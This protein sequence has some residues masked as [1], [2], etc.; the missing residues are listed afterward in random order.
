MELKELLSKSLCLDL[1]TTHGGKIFKIGAVFQEHAFEKQG[2]FNLKEALTELDQFGADATYVLG[3]NLLGHDLPLLEVLSPQLTLLKKPVID[4]L[5]LSPLAFP[6]NPYHRLVKD[7]KLVRQSVNDP[8]ADARIAASIFADQWE[9]F[10]Q[11]HQQNPRTLDFYRFCF[12]NSDGQ[13]MNWAGVC[14]VFKS[15]GAQEIALEDSLKLLNEV[16]NEKVCKSALRTISKQYIWD[17]VECSTLAYCVAW[18]RVSGHN[19][20]LPPWVRHRFPG[21]VPILRQLRDVPCDDPTC[22]Y[23]RL[24]HDPVGQLQRYFGFSAFRPLPANA[25]GSSLQEAIVRHGMSDQAQLAILPTGGGKSLCFQLPAL[26]RN[27]RRGTLTIVISPLQALMKDQVDNLVAKTGTPYAAALYGMLTPPERGQVLESV[28]MGDVAILYV[29]PEQLRNRSFKEVI[30]QREI[31]CWVFDEAHCLSKW[32]HD[33]RTDYLYAAR[34]IREF[35]KDQQTPIPA[36]TCFTATA[37]KAVEEEIVDY[38]R[39]ELGQEL[40]LFEGGVDRNNLHFEV[41]T[42]SRAEKMERVYNLLSERLMSDGSA[43]I[44]AATRKQTEAIN[45]YLLKKNLSSAAF[46]AGLKVPI[47]KQ[48]QEDFIAGRIQ[49]IVATNA[50]G[51]GIDKDNVR[52]VIHA[53]IPGSLENYL[54]EAGRA[55]RDQ[56]DAECVLLY[57]EH[58]IE[59]QFKMG[60][61]SELS[62]RDI[63]QILRGLRLAKKNRDGEIVITA[64]EILRSD[65]VD[66]SFD[67]SDNQADT[68]VRTAV[69]WLERAGF[70]ERNHNSTGVFQGRPVI[71]NMDEARE[72]ISNLN[73]PVLTKRRWMAVL[74][75]LINANPDEGLSADKLAELPEFIDAPEQAGEGDG[76]PRMADSQRILK[77]LNDMA[78]AGLIKR[79]LLLTAFVRYKIANHSMLA[80]EKVCELETA[81]LKVLQEE[82]PDA[83]GWLHLSPRRVNQ[84]LLD[85]GFASVPEFLLSILASLARDGKG[86]AGQRGSLDLIYRNA[87]H[88]LIKLHRDWE[89][90]ITISRL[91]SD[92]A[93]TL[94]KAILGK[95]PDATPPSADILVEFSLDDLVAALKGDLFLSGQV[96][97]E[98]AAIERALMFLHEQKIIV[99]QQ[100]LAVFRQAMTIRLLETK[101]RYTKGDYS[102][103][104]HHYKERVFQVHVMNEY[105]RL[106]V[107]KIKQALGLVT[108]YFAMD[109]R[110]FVQR[111]FAGQKEVLE[112]ATS[113]DSYRRIVDNLGNPVQM[114]IVSA[115]VNENMLVLAGPGSGKTRVVVHRCAYLLRVARVP[116]SSVLILCFNRQAAS[117]LRHRLWELVGS[118]AIGVTVLTYHGLAMRLTG[119]SFADKLAQG[120][121]D[122]VDFDALIDQAIRLLKGEEELPGL[123]QDELRDRLLA[124]YQ[125]ILVD[126]YQDIDQRQYDLVSA[127]AG[128]TLDDED[129]KLTIMAVG[130]DD[131]NIYTFRG[132]NVAFIRQFEKD[133]QARFHHLVENFRSTANIIAAGNA[134]ISENR[135][136]MKITHPIKINKGR[137][138]LVPGGDWTHLDA[139]TK[140]RVQILQVP[141]RNAQA[142]ALAAQLEKLKKCN[143]ALLWA[144]CAVLARTHEELAIIRTALEYVE[145][146]VTYTRQD[147]SL[148]IGRVR[149]IFQFVAT[150]EPLRNDLKRAS[151]LEALLIDAAGVKSV[152]RN[153]WWNLLSICL[154]AWHEETGNSEL[155][156]KQAIDYLWEALAEQKR[157]RHMGRGVFLSSVHY[158]KGT[159]FDHVFVADGGW[160]EK[161]GEEE[162][163]RRVYY[164]AMTRAKQ[165]L[166]LFQREDERNP[167]CDI[168]KRKV[169]G[170]QLVTFTPGEKNIPD[171]VLQRRYDIIGLKDVFLDYAGQ[172]RASSPVHQLLEL[173]MVG[174]LVQFKNAG[175]RLEVCNPAGQPIAVLSKSAKEKWTDAQGQIE[176]IKVLAIV[177]RRTDDSKNPDYKNLLQVESW[178]VPVLE[179][180]WSVP[181]EMNRNSP[182]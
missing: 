145:I 56:H 171:A 102:P 110:E 125:H 108:A 146:P 161:K 88:Y 147:L 60:A 129:A 134:H 59:T 8:V 155:P 106:G 153:P 156:V 135:D 80:L 26:V 167:Y 5:Y 173:T 12:E 17:P 20:V 40:R 144:D 103:L 82:E 157:D 143:P 93:K 72:K 170:E 30:S 14:E 115:P 138:R 39:R 97:N 139:F 36:I 70:V 123:V 86:L 64:G 164:V 137:E 104:E 117:T 89:A 54:Q 71:R 23:C 52:L 176:S 121:D 15:L 50:F 48:I 10:E 22:E 76:R 32:G 78:E 120:G 63:W 77:T 149:E 73:L 105:A 6:E 142:K 41:Q 79:D 35:S 169:S 166:T 172:M 19:S 57:D 47:K 119:T 65:I 160:N 38:F 180:V 84:R 66:T 165:T 91:R 37:K 109:K 42:I 158:A 4:T 90:L 46:H 83:E 68:K 34:F 118:D 113:Q 25:D 136:R 11:L 152:S 101:R 177:E 116:A 133:Y 151:D 122:G 13:S 181:T 81:L 94:L 163:E 24:N 29:S 44:Y 131:Q 67:Q 107:E 62:L 95:I 53:E 175:E 178:E 159:E 128:R 150:L 154:Q 9:A 92:L 3:H 2:R 127:I 140:G 114:A 99:L 132:A 31:G 126:E 75:A 100:G 18:L 96:K 168:L 74:S 179:V 174:D 182:C 45:D 7:Y 85:Q 148:P 112:R 27:F 69:A 43:V 61:M 111:F 130:D 28:R 98:L 33:F 49:V 162:E 21:T 124:G 87:E 51:M 55:G 141:D 1:E 58:D 16:T